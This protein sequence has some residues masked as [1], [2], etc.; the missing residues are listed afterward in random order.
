[1]V[2]LFIG[3]WELLM[4]VCDPCCGWKE[5]FE[6]EPQLKKDLFSSKPAQVLAIKLGLILSELIRL[7]E[8]Q[9]PRVLGGIVAE[10][11][12]RHIEYGLMS[13]HVAPF[14]DVMIASLKKSVTERGH[15]WKPR[16]TK[17][18][19]WA[20]T[21]ISTLLMEAVNQGRPKVETLNKYVHNTNMSSVYLIK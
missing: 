20:I 6:T 16:T 17:A 9:S 3:W 12:L 1:M 2:S 5:L 19:K 18:W 7:L 10:M 8:I 11:A 21:E 4:V 14:R 15:K 13:E